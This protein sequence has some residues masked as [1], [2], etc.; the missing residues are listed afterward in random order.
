MVFYKH[1]G[2]PKYPTL[3]SHSTALSQM[4]E[5]MSCMMMIVNILID[6]IRVSNA[7]REE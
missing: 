3:E 6:A 7:V 1:V 2:S 4:V 5:S